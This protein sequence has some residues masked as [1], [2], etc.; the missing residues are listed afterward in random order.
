MAVDGATGLNN[1]P[2]VVSTTPVDGALSNQFPSTYSLTF[3]EPL[4]EG[5]VSASD[6]LIN[7][8]PVATGVTQ[9]DPFT[10]VFDVDPAANVGDGTYTVLLACR[11]SRRPCLAEVNE[12]YSR[13]RSNSM[14]PGR[15]CST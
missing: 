5:T 3:S 15:V 10:F 6:L 11:C 8:Q 13:P 1:P 4:L 14:P 12:S 9:I 7:G 2:Q